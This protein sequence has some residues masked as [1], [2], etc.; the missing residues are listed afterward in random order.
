MN[1][2]HRHEIRDQSIR[3]GYV[4]A[5]PCVIAARVVPNQRI[6]AKMVQDKTIADRTLAQIKS[7]RKPASGASKRIKALLSDGR[8]RTYG[9]IFQAL[10]ITTRSHESSARQIMR[11]M[12]DQGEITKECVGKSLTWRIVQ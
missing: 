9:D 11:R 10:E 8:W 2:S 4:P 3:N 12:Y 7:S 1:L 5:P 6:Y